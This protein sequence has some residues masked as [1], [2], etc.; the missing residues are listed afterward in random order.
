M[1]LIGYTMMCGQSGPK[2]LV[3][4]V[5]LADEARFGFVVTSDRYFPCWRQKRDSSGGT[6]S[7]PFLPSGWPAMNS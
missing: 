5:A 7:L 4:D 1:T 6:T 3:R 2:Q